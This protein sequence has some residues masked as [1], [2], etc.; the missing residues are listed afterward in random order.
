MES[1]LKEIRTK[2]KDRREAHLHEIR[3]DAR[4]LSSDSGEG[5]LRGRLHDDALC[6]SRM[7]VSSHE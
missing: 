6:M 7:R 2:E 4:V 1:I 5:G 3:I